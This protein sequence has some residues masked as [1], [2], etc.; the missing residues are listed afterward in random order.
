M[1]DNKVYLALHSLGSSTSYGLFLMEYCS[2]NHQHGGFIIWGCLLLCC[3]T[4]SPFFPPLVCEPNVGSLKGY[5]GDHTTCTIFLGNC[6]IVFS[7]LPFLHRRSSV[8]YLY[9]LMSGC[10][11][12]EQLIACRAFSV[13]ANDLKKD[14][15]LG[16][17]ELTWGGIR[18]GKQVSSLTIAN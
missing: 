13:F 8:V 17:W 7:L 15:V 18:S 6:A 3:N 14:L 10:T 16:L 11:C 2:F 12:G 9:H 5:D 4:A 1:N